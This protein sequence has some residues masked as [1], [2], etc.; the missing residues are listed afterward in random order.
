[1]LPQDDT[2]REKKKEETV[3]VVAG[4]TF[5]FLRRQLL[6]ATAV[7]AALGRSEM[8]SGEY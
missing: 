1:M 5:D 4:Q 6:H 3:K 8:S 7:K 2:K